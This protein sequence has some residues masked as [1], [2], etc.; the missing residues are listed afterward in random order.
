[1]RLGRGKVAVPIGLGLISAD[2][3]WNGDRT[4]GPVREISDKQEA[5]ISFLASTS[6]WEFN[7]GCLEDCKSS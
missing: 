6:F 4:D 7:D 5:N 2:E 3:K 1:M